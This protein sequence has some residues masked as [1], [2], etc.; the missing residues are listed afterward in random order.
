MKPVSH[1]ASENELL[2]GRGLWY[3]VLAL[4]NRGASWD[5]IVEVIVPDKYPPE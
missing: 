1:Y 3:K 4:R 5:G 2:L